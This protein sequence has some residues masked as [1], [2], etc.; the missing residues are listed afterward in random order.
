MDEWSDID[1]EPCASALTKEEKEV[2]EKGRFH[3]ELLRHDRIEGKVCRGQ[4]EL[5]EENLEDGL[6]REIKDQM[7]E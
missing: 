4:E 2:L 5:R 1:A 3:E 6:S 7:Y